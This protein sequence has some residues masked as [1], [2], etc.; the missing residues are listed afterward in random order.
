MPTREEQIR[1]L[2]EELLKL[3]NSPEPP[4]TP[5]H[6]HISPTERRTYI[7]TINDLKGIGVDTEYVKKIMQR[8][9]EVY[10]KAE[11]YIITKALYEEYDRLSKQNP[12]L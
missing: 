8:V 3:I 4:S 2:S 12:D 7:E 11:N 6:K 10:G 1:L 5:V 9:D